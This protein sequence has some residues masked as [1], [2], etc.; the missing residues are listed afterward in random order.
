MEG[1]CYV[2]FPSAFTPNGDGFNDQFKGLNGYNVK[3]YRLVIVNRW[4][5]QVFETSDIGSGWN[6]D[7]NGKRAPVGTY[8][9]FCHFTKPGDVYETKLSGTLALIK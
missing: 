6:G 1:P 8:V 2:Q 3:D 5:Q 9:W 4:G 7:L